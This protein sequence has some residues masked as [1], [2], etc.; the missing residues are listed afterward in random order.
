MFLILF[1]ALQTIFSVLPFSRICPPSWTVWI[2]LSAFTRPRALWWKNTG[3]VTLMHFASSPRSPAFATSWMP[4]VET[5]RRQSAAR[6][7]SKA[8]VRWST[9][10]SRRT[11]RAPLCESA[12]AK[13]QM[14]APVMWTSG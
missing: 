6:A 13:V 9:D 10:R 5:A 1:L 11:F 8:P 12:Y 3:G 14:G 4:H 7:L 2:S